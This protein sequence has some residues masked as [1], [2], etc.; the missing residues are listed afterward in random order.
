MDRRVKHSI[1]TRIEAARHFDAGFSYFAV[2]SLLGISKGTARHWQ[3]SNKQGRLIG[4]MPMG[5]KTY[6]AMLKVAA[7]EKFLSGTPKTDVL[8]EFQIS[9]R[10]LFDKWIVIYR[11]EGT[12][13]LQAMRLGRKPVVAT[14]ES[15]E[16][17]VA[18]LEM[19]NAILKKWVALARE[20]DQRL[21][22]R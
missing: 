11:R 8:E 19:E 17:K 18:R 10:S 2:A 16:R 20:E 22:G 13:G 5:K 12:D 4:F 14:A 21:S 1:E 7:V 15:L 3:D 6:P 9:N